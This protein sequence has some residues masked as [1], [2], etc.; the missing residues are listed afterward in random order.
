MKHYNKV[1]DY[2]TSMINMID[3]LDQET[4]MELKPTISEHAYEIRSYVREWAETQELEMKSLIEQFR[5]IEALTDKL[6]KLVNDK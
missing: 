5:E 1:L 4:V 2:I 3:D 6:G